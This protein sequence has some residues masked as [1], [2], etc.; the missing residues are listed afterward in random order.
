MVWWMAVLA[1]ACIAVHSPAIPP[2]L[3]GM[4]PT[5][6]QPRPFSAASFSLLPNAVLSI[7]SPSL[8]API[9][10]HL[11]A[12]HPAHTHVTTCPGPCHDCALGRQTYGCLS[13][14]PS[15]TRNSDATT[16]TDTTDATD[17]IADNPPLYPVEEKDA[18]IVAITTVLNTLP[19]SVPASR[20]ED[21]EN[22]TPN[23]TTPN[24]TTPNPT[25]PNP[26]RSFAPTKPTTVYWD[27]S[28]AC[29]AVNKG[30]GT[31]SESEGKD[32]GKGD[33]LGTEG[34]GGT[35]GEVALVVGVVL[36]TLILCGLSIHYL[37]SRSRVHHQ[38]MD[39]IIILSPERVSR[40]AGILG[41]LSLSSYPRHRQPRQPTP[42]SSTQQRDAD[43][44][45][46]NNSSSNHD[47][48]D[49]KV[50][51]GTRGVR[52]RRR[53]SRNSSKM[54]KESNGSHTGEIPSLMRTGD[55]EELGMLLVH[56]GAELTAVSALQSGLSDYD[57]L[58]SSFPE[59]SSDARKRGG[60]LVPH[61]EG[62]PSSSRGGGMRRGGKRG[63]RSPPKSTPASPHVSTSDKDVYGKP[64]RKRRTSGDTNNGSGSILQLPKSRSRPSLSSSTTTSTPQIKPSTKRPPRS[65]KAIRKGRANKSSSLSKSPSREQSS[66]PFRSRR[67]ISMS[68]DGSAFGS[69]LYES[70]L[71]TQP[72]R[73]R[74]R[75]PN[76][77]S[78]ASQTSLDRAART[79][80][81]SSVSRNTR[82]TRPPMR[83]SETFTP[84]SPP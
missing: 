63:R 61:S 41:Q 30:V 9:L 65:A 55:D 43:E 83:R 69:A 33:L 44:N 56:E 35:T 49:D 70:P 1:T 28:G 17:A 76:G 53:K 14:P 6:T 19:S 10:A 26:T 48:D 25:T 84:S 60:Y 50:D 80:R 7:A 11:C 68:S 74:S 23:P 58:D 45:N 2:T 5:P 36:T 40:A 57:D 31:R 22:P 72:P 32:A 13:L 24:P 20:G 18:F 73:T 66:A 29:T 51:G 67:Q 39:N 82:A 75:R 52:G 79:G 71:H 81:R 3:H 37:R 62:K 77:T 27:T 78:S 38:R 47:N 42:S 16:D 54:R 59:C 15:F 46:N 64:K 12:Y 4:T 21:A 34:M 8:S